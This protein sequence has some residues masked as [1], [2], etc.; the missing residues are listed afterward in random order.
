MM[1]ACLMGN[2]DIVKYLIEIETLP[3][4]NINAVDNVN[5]RNLNFFSFILINIY[6]DCRMVRMC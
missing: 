1:Y 2:L 5:E 6:Y 3:F 4:R